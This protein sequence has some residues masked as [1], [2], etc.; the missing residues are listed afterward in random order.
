MVCPV[1]TLVNTHPSPLL[2]DH[3]TMETLDPC[4]WRYVLTMDDLASFRLKARSDVVGTWEI[5][6][7]TYNYFYCQVKIEISAQC[8]TQTTSKS[9][10]SHCGEQSGKVDSA[11]VMHTRVLLLPPDFTRLTPSA[12]M[13]L[14]KDTTPPTG[15]SKAYHESQSRIYKLEAP[16]F[17][18]VGEGTDN[19]DFLADLSALKAID[20][21]E[22]TRA[23]QP[24]NRPV[25]KSESPLLQKLK[26]R[27]SLCLLRLV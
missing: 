2:G 1:D 23:R 8:F 3:V 21:D 27:T 15:A 22:V 14:K 11:Q 20:P 26:R 18:G 5:A 4:A 13:T 9:G 24:E 25:P 7:T 19:L 10:K 12:F 6:S 16:L 17:V